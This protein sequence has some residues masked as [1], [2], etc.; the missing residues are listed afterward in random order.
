MM[1]GFL[2]GEARKVKP[3]VQTKIALENGNVSVL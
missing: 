2:G 3:I 1:I